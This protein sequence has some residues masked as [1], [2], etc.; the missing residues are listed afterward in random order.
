MVF[1]SWE[2]VT[3]SSTTGT[4]TITRVWSSLRLNAG[5]FLLIQ[6]RADKAGVKAQFLHQ[7]GD[8]LWVG[9]YSGNPAPILRGGEPGDPAIY[10]F[11]I[12]QHMSPPSNW[13]DL[14]R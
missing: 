11:K 8:L 1:S 10:S 4:S 9:R 14:T 7:I 2:S 5:G 6:R 13:A 12:V 3:E